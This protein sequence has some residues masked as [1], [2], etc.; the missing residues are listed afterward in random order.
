MS[1]TFLGVTT[2]VEGGNVTGIER[3]GRLPNAG[4]QRMPLPPTKKDLLGPKCQ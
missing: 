1:G 2:G 4:I 3:P